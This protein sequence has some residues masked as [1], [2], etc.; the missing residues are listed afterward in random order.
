MPR[1]GEDTVQCTLTDYTN[2]LIESVV[3]QMRSSKDKNFAKLPTLQHQEAM[4]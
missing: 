4:S 3:C 1:S 2:S